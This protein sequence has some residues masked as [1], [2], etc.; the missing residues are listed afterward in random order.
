MK[1]VRFWKNQSFF[2]QFFITYV[3]LILIPL[4][5][6]I[7]VNGAIVREFQAKL[8][9]TQLSVLRQT[10]DVVERSI[11]DLEWRVFQ[12]GANPRINRLI[13]EY[14]SGRN[15][16][17]GLI[18]EILA[19]LNTFTLYSGSLRS[20]F[21]LYLKEPPVI[22]TPYALYRHEDF[23]EG[24]SFFDMEGSTI[25][26]W[27]AEIFS[28]YYRRGFFPSRR[29]TIE[30]FINQPMIPYVQSF[31]VALGNQNREIDGVLVYFI[32]EAEFT[33]LLNNLSLP[34]G[35]WAYI[36]DQ[37]NQIISGISK[38]PSQDFRKVYI[39]D[40]RKEALQRVQIDGEDMFV[41]HTSSDTGWKYAAVLPAAP[42]LSPVV[43]L[44][45]ISLFSLLISLAVCMLVASIIS[46][47]RAKP[48]KHLLILLQQ[49]LGTDDIHGT[50]LHALDS[51]VQR[52]IDTSRHLQDQLGKQELFHQNLLVNRLLQGSFRNRN[53]IQSFLEYMDLTITEKRF[54]ALI[55][56]ING[57]DTL[58]TVA[59][60]QEMNRTKVILKDIIQKTFQKKVFI[61][62]SQ[63]EQISLVYMSNE[64]TEEESAQK[65]EK[66]LHHIFDAF[67]E[68]H[69]AGTSA[70]IGSF[71]KEILEIAISYEEAKQAL[72][73]RHRNKETEIIR[74]SE[75]LKDLQHC[76]YPI[77]LELR[78]TNAVKAGDEQT[79]KQAF[80]LLKTENFEQ[81]QISGSQIR[82]LYH[83]LYGSF[84]KLT[85]Q[86][87]QIPQKL[88]DPGDHYQIG[89][90]CPLDKLMDQFFLLTESIHGSKRS[91]NRKLID[92]IIDFLQDSYQDSGLCLYTVAQRFSITES[93]LSF[94]FK[95]QT[96]SNFSSYIEK[97]RIDNAAKLLESTQAN[98]LEVAKAVGYTNDKTFRR[99]FKKLKG[100]SPSDYRLEAENKR[101]I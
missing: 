99:V 81:R 26:Q 32:S 90:D 33:D 39:P 87:V 79:L 23:E 17:T 2:F 36:A 29:V 82:F 4:G 28:R 80:N 63:E 1:Q 34:P 101:I 53:E 30:E 5:I 20:T 43:R 13:N 18:R 31:P 68:I 66:G 67:R 58:D 3:L 51:S 64:D 46:Y 62:D 85:D 76:Y 78:I 73:T 92:G 47:R 45:R 25:E 71:R 55:I 93:Y 77:E 16:D 75:A 83:E 59:I 54:A 88:E 44:Q 94:F 57:F 65:L 38:E 61:Y 50:N 10:R 84:R 52:L 89:E 19:N 42:L 37:N 14:S 96:G 35:G 49:E 21:Y 12:I 48:L 91:H 95:E 9:E 74:Y 27:H 98:I 7:G 70:G 86:L 6:A 11:N 69:P 56:R 15:I 40:D 22:L 72:E 41:I 97:L 60:I 24:R 100:L 8:E